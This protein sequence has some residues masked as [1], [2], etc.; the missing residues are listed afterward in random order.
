MKLK[1]SNYFKTKDSEQIFYT[2]NFKPEE[3]E[4]DNVLIFNYGLV[5][6]NY[7]WKYQLDFFD[8]HGYKILIHD[9]R[10]HYQS[11]G[12][13]D[14]ESIT[15]E[16]ITNDLYALINHLKIKKPILIA[17]SMGVNISLEFA[18]KFPEIP[19]KLI[20]ISGTIM[21]V[22][23]IM[24]DSNIIDQVQPLIKKLLDTYPKAFETF[25]KF[26]GWNP[27]V[28]K[29]IH[30]GGFN[31]KQVPKEFIEVYLNK[32]GRL[33]PHIFF[34]LIGQ[35]HTHQILGEVEIIKTKTLTIGG[36]NDK[37]IPNHLQRLLSL[38][39][40]NSELYIV[41]NGSHVPQADFPNLINERINLFL[42]S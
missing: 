11:S 33:G 16:N 7:H 37:V 3:R 12:S 36:D 41:K 8:S 4:H 18:K 25:W 31:I 14:I 17:H 39:L 1:L 22:Y 9:Y 13:K 30:A 38:T 26:G 10:G 6:S 23:N 24:F 28:K 40:P 20:L 32:V 29:L 5:C 27:I 15:F 35:M 34:Q 19:S 42:T 21:P 2:T